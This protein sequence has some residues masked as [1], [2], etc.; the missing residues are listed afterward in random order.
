[1][2]IITPLVLGSRLD[3]VSMLSMVYYVNLVC[4]VLFAF[5]NFRKTGL[6]AFALLAF[7]LS[8]TLLGFRFLSDY[9]LIPRGSF[10]YY[11]ILFGKRLF[12]PLYIIAQISIPISIALRR[13]KKIPP[14][15]LDK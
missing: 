7:V 14:S 10:V 13:L 1:M 5:M 15:T 4:N 2:L 12:Y 3:A 11:V 6:F 8:D 9:F